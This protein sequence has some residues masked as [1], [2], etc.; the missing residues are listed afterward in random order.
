MPSK[1]HKPSWSHLVERIYTIRRL[2]SWRW[3]LPWKV[4]F[5]EYRLV[6]KPDSL[7]DLASLFYGGKKSRLLWVSEESFL[8]LNGEPNCCDLPKEEF[9][10]DFFRINFSSDRYAELEHPWLSLNV[11]S[12]SREEANKAVALLFEL[13]D[14]IYHSVTLLLGTYF[15]DQHHCPCPLDASNL[16]QLQAKY[17]NVEFQ[18]V[19]FVSSEQS[20]ALAN[21]VQSSRKLCLTSCKFSDGGSSFVD[22]FVTR[23]KTIQN[24]CACAKFAENLPFD[25]RNLIKFLESLK[26]Q[27]C[28]QLTLELYDIY[29]LKPEVCRAIADAEVKELNLTHCI[30]GDQGSALS[31]NIRQ[32]RGPKGLSLDAD[33]SLPLGPFQS[34]NG[35]K[36]FLNS[37]RQARKLKILL[38]SLWMPPGDCDDLLEVLADAMAE[39]R[40]LEVLHIDGYLRH[41]DGWFELVH[42]VS[43]HPS[44]CA[45]GL[46]G[47]YF[48]HEGSNLLDRKRDRTNAIIDMLA[49]NDQLEEICT[50][51]HSTCDWRLWGS[52]VTP[53]L[54]CNIYRKRFAKVSN[55]MLGSTRAARM[56]RVLTSV[57]S[58]PSLMWLLLSMNPDCVVTYGLQR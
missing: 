20:C 14:T 46:P 5:S 21:M 35:W 33:P 48:E 29:L 45:L 12:T 11:F 42:A 23:E 54:E 15:L 58:K 19:T 44:L 36:I 55:T 50:N 53:K 28:E 16:A 52:S 7:Y 3:F 13:P 1:K 51:G 32:G 40:S 24:K 25:E 31:E 8:T 37:L 43:Q 41:D 27:K 4:R 10:H 30:L 39:N 22:E 6:Q 38:M 2:F 49:V 26:G 34:M 57:S 17:Q 56:G 47:I 9:R 18:G